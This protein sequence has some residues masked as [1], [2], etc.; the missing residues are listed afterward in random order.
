MW[1]SVS[2]YLRLEHSPKQI[3]GLLGINHE[4]ICRYVYRDKK[5]SGCLLHLRCQKPCRKPCTGSNRARRGQI[6]NQR[7]IDERPSKN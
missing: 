1:H 2:H 6:L 3:A 4:T 5:A 7:R